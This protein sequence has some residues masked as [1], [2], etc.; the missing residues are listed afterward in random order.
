M[1]C[2]AR[3]QISHHN[4]VP[5]PRPLPLK[6]C[7]HWVQS[8]FQWG[9]GAAHRVLPLGCPLPL[10]SFL[11]PLPFIHNAVS[12]EANVSPVVSGAAAG[13]VLGFFRSFF[14]LTTRAISSSTIVPGSGP[15]GVFF[16]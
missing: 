16:D 4:G 10:E 6:G 3:L 15:F 5:R 13:C 7:C 2:P 14:V 1:E 11:P 12:G 9:S 8:L